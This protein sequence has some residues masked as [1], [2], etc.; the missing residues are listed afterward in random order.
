MII[1]DGLDLSII[2]CDAAN[3][4]QDD[5]VSKPF[6]VPEVVERMKALINTLSTPTSPA[7]YITANG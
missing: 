4:L 3:F 2:F 1:A 7:D 6:R 5:V